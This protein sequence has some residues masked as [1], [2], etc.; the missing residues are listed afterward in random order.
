MERWRKMAAAGLAAVGIPFAALLYGIGYFGGPVF[1]DIPARGAPPPRDA[2][3]AVVL[4]SGNMGFHIGQAAKVSNGLAARGLPVVGIN[5]L[6]YFRKPRSPAE[7]TALVEAAIDRAVRD[8]HRDK[9]ALIGISFGADILHV[10]LAGLPPS[11][12]AKVR[13]VVLVVPGAILQLQ[14]SPLEIFPIRAP[15][16]DGT[17]TGRQLDWA[18]ATCI[19]GAEEKDSLCPLL[20]LP[21]MRMEPLAGGHML[22]RDIDLMTARLVQ[23]IDAAAPD[24]PVSGAATRPGSAASPPAPPAG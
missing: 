18:P 4:F 19:W 7:T 22:N 17:V 1:F 12:R 20:A 11:Y 24:A 15:D 3:V 10:G 8:T 6:T 23:A 16:R 14:A 5:S 21:N 13:N 9:V 2:D